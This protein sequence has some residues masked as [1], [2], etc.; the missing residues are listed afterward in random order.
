M[1]LVLP[2]QYHDLGRGS[3]RDGSHLITRP[4]ILAHIDRF[5]ANP[6]VKG[7]SYP[8]T[9]EIQPG[10]LDRSSGRVQKGFSVLK[11]RLIE[12]QWTWC[13]GILSLG[14][15]LPLLAGDIRLASYLLKFVFSL[16]KRGL[17]LLKLKAMIGI[18]YPEQHIP[19]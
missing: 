17:C 15:D 18:V 1:Q 8:G 7:R 3:G 14:H 6:A 12:H 2:Q 13:P 4:D 10:K 16:G 11:L 5:A 9:V 19:L